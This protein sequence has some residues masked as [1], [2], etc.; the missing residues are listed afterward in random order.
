MSDL[1]PLIKKNA[2]RKHLFCG[3]Y[4]LSRNIHSYK[5][6]PYQKKENCMFR[7]KLRCLVYNNTIFRLN[8]NYFALESKYFLKYQLM[9]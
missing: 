3:I 4:P 7:H 8:M 5:E 1:L 6:S 9:E 2:I